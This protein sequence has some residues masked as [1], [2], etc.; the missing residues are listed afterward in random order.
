MIKNGLKPLKRIVKKTPAH[1]VF[2]T[3]SAD[4]PD[5]SLDTGI[6]GFP[7]QDADGAPYSCSG[8]TRA[9]ILTDLL[10]VKMSPDFA[11]AAAVAMMQASSDPAGVDLLDSME[12]SVAW[13]EL[14][15]A[16]APFTAKSMGEAYSCLFA[17][18][19]PQVKQVALK[20][21]QNGIL[22]ALGNGSAFYSILSNAYLGKIGIS[23]G[24]PWFREWFTPQPSPGGM[25]SGIV[26]MPNITDNL[27]DLG[28]HN[29]EITGQQSISGKPYAVVKSWQGTQV[30]DGGK[31]YFSE[32]VLNAALSIPGTA[33]LTFNPSAIRWFSLL[34]I[35]INRFPQ[36]I[37]L[38]PQLI[39]A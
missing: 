23:V 6:F 5:F 24:T 19:P 13:G 11:Y 32:E 39:N 10:Q 21:T 14:P 4:I 15:I 12:S 16:I 27:Q 28:W 38:L 35:L 31:L 37:P 18:W 36:I 26:A 9:A 30:G 1:H 2:G 22:N 17:N 34:G 25:Q 29:Y 33:A 20:Y 7:N 8:Y 3:V